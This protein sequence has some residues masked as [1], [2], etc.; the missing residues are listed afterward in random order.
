MAEPQTSP[1]HGYMECP[2]DCCNTDLLEG[3]GVYRAH[4]THLM[5][6]PLA[7]RKCGHGPREMVS[8]AAQT[9]RVLELR[10]QERGWERV[11]GLGRSRDR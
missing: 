6:S 2:A 10:G 3:C 1:T 7:S 5:N 11:G 8:F 4:A 9:Q